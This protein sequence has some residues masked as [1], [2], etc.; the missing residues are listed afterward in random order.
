MKKHLFSLTI[1]LLISLLITCN[2]KNKE[3]PGIAFTFDD[4]NILEWYGNRDL[5]KEYGIRATFF[6]NR[7]QNLTFEQVLMLKQLKED[8]HE[9]A[10]HSMNHTNL[11]DFL[12]SHSIKEY[13]DQEILPAIEKMKELGFDVKSYAYPFGV[14]TPEVDEELLKYFNILR[15]ATYNIESTSLDKIDRIFTKIGSGG[16]VDAMGIDC[17]YGITLENLERGMKRASSQNEVLVV[18]AHMIVE[19]A[20][21]YQTSHEYLKGAFKLSKKYNLKSIPMLELVNTQQ[22]K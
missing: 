18:Y 4:Q 6:I 22:I 20:T 7:P 14:S 5:F 21:G 12:L 16:V 8:G 2:K 3:N 13:I 11:N 17:Q 1:L 10:C 15:K 9:I 19:N